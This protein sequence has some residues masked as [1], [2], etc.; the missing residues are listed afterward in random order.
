VNKTPSFFVNGRSLPSFAPDQ[1]AGLL[2]EEVARI[3]KGKA[4]SVRLSN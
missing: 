4:T 2:A 1:L 3:A